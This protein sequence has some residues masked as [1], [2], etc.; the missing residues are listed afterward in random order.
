[1]DSQEEGIFLQLLN[2]I[3]GIRFRGKETEDSA[4]ALNEVSDIDILFI[5]RYMKQ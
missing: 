5:N 2:D 4:N 3:I 1:M